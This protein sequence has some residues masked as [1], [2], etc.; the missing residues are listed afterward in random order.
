MPRDQKLILTPDRRLRVF[1][2]ST[3][4]E[5]AEE[6]AA[7]RSAVEEIRM[8]PV[9]FELGARPYPPRDLY[10]AYLA[11]SD[12]FI[13]IYWQSYGWIAP[14]MDISG[15]EDEFL[16]SEGMP[17]LI[18]V[19]EPAPDREPRLDT[20][21]HDRIANTGVSYRKFT[22]PDELG[23]LIRDDLAILLT[24]RFERVE[25]GTPELEERPTTK[26]RTKLPLTTNR[27]IG[28][29][30]EIAD[31]SA[32]LMSD[33]VR[34]VTLI[35]PGGVGKSRLAIDLG[36]ALKDRFPD[37]VH[38]VM[39]E[40]VSDPGEVPSALAAS[41]DLTELIGSANPSDLV[42][43]FLSQREMLLILDNFEHVVEA[44]P[45][46]S[47]LLANCPG[48]RI[49]VTS[50]TILRLR[51]EHDYLLLPLAVPEEGDEPVS[52]AVELFLARADRSPM[53]E[54]FEQREAVAEICRRLEGL[55]LAI[56]LAAARTSILPPSE[57]L[58]RLDDRLELLRGQLRDFPERQQTMRTA[59][60]WSVDLLPEEDQLF[61]RRASVFTGGFSL[62]AVEK[63]CDPTGEL[64]ALERVQNL[65]DSSLVIA[66][67]GGSEPRMRMLESIRQFAA[68]Q[69]EASGERRTF[70]ERHADHFLELIEWAGPELRSERQVATLDR[71]ESE[72]RNLR[73]AL[74]WLLDA[75]RAE[76]VSQ[77]GWRIWP[78]WWIRG[79]LAEGKTIMSAAAADPNLSPLGRAR[80]Q[81]GQ[82]TMC[83]FIGEHGE[84]VY[85]LVT[86]SEQL[87][88]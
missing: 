4:A 81:A 80:A 63:V 84:A 27:L 9:L 86:A 33:D 68:E 79:R 16:L 39:L 45:F 40:M 14:E 8:H 36:S 66:S 75:G 37:G 6:R 31:V 23:K 67:P 60:A 54:S 59:I 57:I 71:L 10:R 70:A 53:I 3:I 5:L 29:T 44:G 65:I 38:F 47:E 73:T 64:D 25:H 41:L 21:L 77:A 32:L 13:G 56:E 17:R 42:M 20:L 30:K 83:L 43:R 85:L 87:R 18:Y 34:L 72:D 88:A 15:L 46:V 51:G 82:G 22:T 12:I 24:E 19:K 69:L 58:K 26:L 55:P 76:E 62:D 61:F 74:R 49:L 48:L 28:R 50:R 78:F 35:G 52:E 7:A 2:S 11:Q 1:I